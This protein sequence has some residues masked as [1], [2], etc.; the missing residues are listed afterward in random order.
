L[1]KGWG[2]GK[3]YTNT[4]K[5]KLAT[6]HEVK[7]A[8][9]KR[10]MA[11]HESKQKVCDTAFWHLQALKENSLYYGLMFTYGHSPSYFY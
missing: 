7:T 3:A 2:R 8:F 10:M 5:P 6:K 4:V 9:Q 11:V 1:V